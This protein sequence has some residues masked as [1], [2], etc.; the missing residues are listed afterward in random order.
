MSVTL[1]WNGDNWRKAARKGVCK[2]PVAYLPCGPKFTDM[3]ADISRGLADIERLSFHTSKRP[4]ATVAEVDINRLIGTWFEVARLPKLQANGFG[5]RGVD[6]TA[7]YE[8]RPD[9]TIGVQ[10]VSYKAKARMRRTEVNGTA[11]PTNPSRLQ[12]L[13]TFTMLSAGGFGSLD[14]TMTTAG[15]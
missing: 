8:K 2:L 15:R 14:S 5:Q 6:V 10:T 12:R 7:T 9:G 4:P 1:H 11:R 13:L 3:L